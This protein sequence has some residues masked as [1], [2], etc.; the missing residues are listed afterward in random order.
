MIVVEPCLRLVF[1]NQ[2]APV[3]LRTGLVLK[4][5]VIPVI[6]LP[7]GRMLLRVVLP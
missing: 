6:I 4:R 7:E 2:V 1:R 3:C 5:V